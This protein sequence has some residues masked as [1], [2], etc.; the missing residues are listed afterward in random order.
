MP[1]IAAF[2][3]GA[4]GRSLTVLGRMRGLEQLCYSPRWTLCSTTPRLQLRTL[5]L[6]ILERPVPPCQYF[7]KKA[8]IV[9]FGVDA[10]GHRGRYAHVA[11]PERPHQFL[12]AV[13]VFELEFK[14]GLVGGTKAENSSCAVVHFQCERDI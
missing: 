13:D 1:F 10:H 2:S 12:A 8:R 4:L 14:F 9:Q 6:R 11:D 5:K 7:G 3:D